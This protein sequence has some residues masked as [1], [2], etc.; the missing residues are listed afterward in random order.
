MPIGLVIKHQQRHRLAL[1]MLPPRLS[2]ERR[3]LGINK[4]SVVTG[5]SWRRWML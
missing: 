3:D 2:L 5:Q 1:T 4:D